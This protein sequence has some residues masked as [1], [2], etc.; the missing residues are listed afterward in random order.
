MIPALVSSMVCLCLGMLYPA[1][2][3]YK[4]VR[5]KN[6]KEYVKWMMYWIVFALFKTIETFTDVFFS[7]WFPFYYEIKIVLL[8]YLLSPYTKGSSLL[9]RQ[10]VHPALVTKEQEIDDMLNVAQTRS[11]KTVME[12]VQGGVKYIT[13]FVVE[14]VTKAP[15]I[16]GEMMKNGQNMQQNQMSAYRR[17]ASTMETNNENNL[18]RIDDENMT[19]DEIE[20]EIFLDE[21]LGSESSDDPEFRPMV[22]VKKT[23]SRKPSTRMSTRK[24]QQ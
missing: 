23:Q 9:Y 19:Y 4:A 5:A 22:K 13:G 14:S 11:Y 3:S 21:D 15:C 12:L 18:L 16:L 17:K 1:Y 20:Q 7:F 6:V 2:A 24:N 10:F 8:V